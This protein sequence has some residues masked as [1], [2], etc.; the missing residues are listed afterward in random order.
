[1]Y[2][3]L[4]ITNSLRFFLLSLILAFNQFPEQDASDIV[5]KAD[6][7]MRGK[8]SQAELVIITSRANWSRKMDVKTWIKGTDYSMI[9]IQSPI[10]DKG[11]VFLKRGKEVWNSYNFV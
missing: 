9:L 2:I 1:M 11:T 5:K 10:K 7:K 6:E 3:I 4:N 8:T